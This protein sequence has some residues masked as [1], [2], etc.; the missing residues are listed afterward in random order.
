M[1]IVD[2]EIV[3]GQTDDLFEAIGSNSSWSKELNFFKERK[4]N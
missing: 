3:E 1:T 2:E 4:E